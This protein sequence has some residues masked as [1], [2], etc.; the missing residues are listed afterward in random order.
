MLARAPSKVIYIAISERYRA[1]ALLLLLK[2]GF[3]VVCLAG[4]IYGVGEQHLSFLKRKG[5]RFRKLDTSK[6]RLPKPRLAV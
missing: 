3:S 4:K 6:I 2:G 1:K 5:I